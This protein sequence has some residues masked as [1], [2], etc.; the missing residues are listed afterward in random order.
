[1]TDE[2]EVFFVQMAEIDTEAPDRPAHWTTQSEFSYEDR[3]Q[4]EHFLALIEP[5]LNPSAGEE[6]SPHLRE[7]V[8]QWLREKEAE[9]EARMTS[10][11]RLRRR[12]DEIRQ[13]LYLYLVDPPQSV[14]RIFRVVSSTELRSEGEDALRQAEQ[15]A[16]HGTVRR[17]DEHEAGDGD[18]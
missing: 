17:S 6:M 11:D 7:R 15:A 10:L 2:G 1:M 5:L 12:V 8:E 9:A 18:A 13:R 16:S 3:A 14:E 4:A